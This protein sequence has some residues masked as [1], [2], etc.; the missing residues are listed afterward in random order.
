MR[1]NVPMPPTA[2]EDLVARGRIADSTDRQAL[3]AA[4]QSP[5]TF[6]CGFDPSAPS[7]HIGSLA[8]LLEMRRLQERGHHPIVLVGGATGM[9]GDPKES[10]E[11]T[12]NQVDV[13]REWTDRLQTQSS[14]FVDF[15]G[16]NPAIM[17][18]NYSWTAEL[19][20]LDLLRDVGKHFSVNRMLDR[21]AV[22]A[23]LESNGISY[24]EFSY[25]LLQSYDYLQLF[26]RHGCTLQIGGSDQ[27]GNITAGVD[28]I[29]RVEGAHVHAF[30]LPLVVKSDGVKYGKTESGTVWLDATMTSPWAFYQFWL[31][32]P[33][34]DVP[35]LLRTYSLKSLDDVEHLVQDSAQS[36]AARIGQRALA[37]EM[38]TLVHSAEDAADV[39]AAAA[40]LFGAAVREGAAGLRG[41]TE[42][43]LA[44][45]LAETHIEQWSPAQSPSEL[46]T[47]DAL[48]L[49]GVVDSRGAARRAIAE[50][51][52]YM[53][54]ERIADETAMVSPDDLIHGRWLVMRRGKRTYGAVDASALKSR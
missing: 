19:S 35:M 36:P 50:G 6:Y 23:R 26:R 12:L 21:E 39:E 40:A 38:T 52:A 31:N 14:A 17:A 27:W 28:L 33:D 2:I 44:A 1:H 42:A 5:V 43:T 16:S 7:L 53:N 45:A 20:A 54:N 3:A 10:G 11:R 9:I 37:Q 25:V 46:T 22:K 24:T 41:L 34:E 15:T 8:T 32:C 4:L 47:V 49:S 18:D 51:G 30:T 29:R 13:V 48:L